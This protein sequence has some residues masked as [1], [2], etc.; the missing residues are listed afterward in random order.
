[1]ADNPKQ[2][3]SKQYT[4]DDFKQDKT[5]VVKAREEKKKEGEIKRQKEDRKSVV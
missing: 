4:K 5:Q 3:S 2:Q 1:M